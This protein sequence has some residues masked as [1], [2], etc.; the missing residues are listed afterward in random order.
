MKNIYLRIKNRARQVVLSFPAQRFYEDHENEQTLSRRLFETDPIVKRLHAFV[1]ENMWDNL[2]HGMNH[3][4]KV[5]LDAG[6]LMYIE[7][8]SLNYPINYID[9]RVRLAQCS[10]LLHD[11]K[12]GQKNHAVKGAEFAKEIM[13]DYGDIS[14]EDV[15]DISNAI[16]NH[17]AFKTNLKTGTPEGDLVSDCLYDADKFRWGPD[18]FSHMVWDMLEY[19]NTPLSKFIHLYPEGIKALEKIKTSFRTSTGKK[20]G[21]SF[22]DTGLAIGDKLYHI[23][24]NEFAEYLE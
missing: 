12:R 8:R 20:Y 17:E 21:P 22:I 18:N 15:T 24:K 10:G 1:S 13:K 6:S 2:G 9:S 14:S 16:Y 7:G 4:T 11:M 23:I 19:S 3:V 5:A